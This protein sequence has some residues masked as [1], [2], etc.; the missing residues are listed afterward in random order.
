MSL[1]NIPKIN[2]TGSRFGRLFV[3]GYGGVKLMKRKD[4]IHREHLWIC[5]CDCGNRSI[6]G[7]IVL[8][9]GN[10]NSC[11]CIRDELRRSR[12]RDLTG[13]RFGRLVVKKYLG[14]GKWRCQCDCGEISRVMGSALNGGHSK[15]CG[16]LARELT[17]K[18]SVT[19][20]HTRIS[21]GKSR[22]TEYRIYSAMLSRCSNPNVAAFPSYGGRGIKVCRRWRGKNG[23]Q[24]FLNDMGCRP[25]GKSLDRIDNNGPYALW[26][27][28]W[29]TQEQQASNT[30][31]NVFVEFNSEKMTLSQAAKRFGMCGG[32]IKYRISHGIPLNAPKTRIGQSKRT[33]Q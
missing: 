15:S 10:T 8:R 16:C 14:N 6:H 17:S 12:L 5:D 27:C 32:S 21:C 9:N 18:R 33:K 7:G 25:K 4:G 22:T 30:R 24:N 23:F 2:L 1:T 28:R 3:V 11:G 29:A 26:N 19:H 31:V 20:G 13:I